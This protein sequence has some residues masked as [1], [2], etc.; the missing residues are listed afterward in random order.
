MCGA[1]AA[2]SMCRDPETVAVLVQGKWRLKRI[3]VKLRRVSQ[4]LGQGVAPRPRRRG[5]PRRGHQVWPRV[6]PRVDLY[7]L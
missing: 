5:R 7:V 1:V 6:E 4:Q 2:D 3:F